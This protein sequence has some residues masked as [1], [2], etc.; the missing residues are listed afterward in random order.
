MDAKV[1][2]PVGPTEVFQRETPN[3]T[4]T[5]SRSEPL[6]E[7]SSMGFPQPLSVTGRNGASQDNVG[8][9]TEEAW[10]APPPPTVKGFAKVVLAERHQT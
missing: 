2:P 7:R 6:N 10:S 8:I 5:R 3:H 1:M 9:G 4:P